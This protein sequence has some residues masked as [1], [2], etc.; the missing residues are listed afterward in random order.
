[1]IYIFIILAFIISA[2]VAWLIIPRILLISLRKKLFDMPDERK[3]H[4]RAIPRLGG[5]SFFPTILISCCFVLALRTLTGYNIPTLQAAYVLPECLFLVCGMTLLYLT[6][7]ADDLVGVRYRQKFIIQILSASFFPIAGLWINDLYGL[8]GIYTI[9]AWIG[10]PFTILTIVFITNAINLIDG[11]DGLA[12][13]LSS[14]ALLVFGILFLE[15]GLWMYSI[16]GFSTFGVLIPF[17]YYNVFGSAERAR[18]IFM[19]DTGSLTLGYILSFL[20]IKYSQNNLE[21]TSYTQGAFVIA[22][23]T[24]IVPAFDVIRVVIVRIR[25]GKSPFE[26]DKNHIHHKFLAMGFTPRKA[27]ITILLVSCT[28][29]ALNILLMPWIDNTVMLLGDIIIWIALNLWWDRV[30][31]KRIHLKSLY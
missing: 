26:P 21:V 12:S 25:N 29:S 13:G 5:V 3:V 2:C 8:F 10:I 23:S 7:I 14:V 17:F 4:K 16:L 28:F 24:L 15:K 31:D 30:K 18:K 6:G 20:A 19:G 22:F 1:M 11:I 27:M 9:S